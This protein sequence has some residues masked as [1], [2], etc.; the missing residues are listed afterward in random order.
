MKVTGLPKYNGQKDLDSIVRY[1]TVDL[2]KS[3]KD[4]ET[5][6]KHLDFASNFKFFS[7]NVTILP[8]AEKEIDNELSK[9]PSFMIV[10]NVS[11]SDAVVS[12]GPTSWTDSKLYV[13]NQG[14]ASVTC[15]VLFFK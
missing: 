11:N 14:A 3:L 6:L 10:A 4:L 12:K 13:K 2:A 1:L 15:D 7:K 5:I 9:V 8:G